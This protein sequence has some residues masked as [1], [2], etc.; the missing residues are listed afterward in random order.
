MWS[1]KATPTLEYVGVI[2]LK[3]LRL[4]HRTWSVRLQKKLQQKHPVNFGLFHLHEYPNIVDIHQ[5][6]QMSLFRQT[7]RTSQYFSFHTDGGAPRVPQT[8]ASAVRRISRAL[9]SLG[10]HEPRKKRARFPRACPHGWSQKGRCLIRRYYKLHRRCTLM[11][12]CFSFIVSSESQTIAH[13]SNQTHLG[14]ISVTVPPGNK[15][16]F[17]I[18]PSSTGACTRKSMD[19]RTNRTDIKGNFPPHMTRAIDLV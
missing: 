14:D 10:R 6:S 17:V 12:D 4:Q 11:S 16:A 5:H 2:L 13:H 15:A 9:R 7:N 18:I 1:S 19:C 3:V 8:R